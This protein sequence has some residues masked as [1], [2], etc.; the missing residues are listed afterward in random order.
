MK[1]VR[2]RIAVLV[3]ADGD[4]RA[5]GG[6]AWTPGDDMALLEED[7]GGD[8]C[9]HVAMWVEADVPV[10]DDD[11]CPPTVE[12]RVCEEEPT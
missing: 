5:L 2:V 8:L 6:M 1:T 11:S 12:G 10:P 7:H 9:P 3:A 4:W